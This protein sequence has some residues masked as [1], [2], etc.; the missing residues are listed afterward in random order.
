MEPT[1]ATNHKYK[2][3]VF[4]PTFNRARTLGH[5]YESLKA[6]TFHNFEWLIV[7]DGSTDN[8]RELL[9]QWRQKSDFPIRYVYQENSGKHV[10]FNLA[11]REAQGELFL[12]LDS[13]DTCV[14]EALA[15]FKFHWDSI[16]DYQR[17][18][19]S[20]VTALCADQHGKVVGDE[21][22]QDVTDSD[23]LEITYRFKVRGE[24]WGFL[25]TEVLRRYPFP[26]LEKQCPYVPEGVIWAA[27]ARRYKT[28]FVNE[29]LRIYWSD[30][31][32]AS[33][34]LTRWQL[35]RRAYG[36]LLWDLSVMNEQIDWFRYAPLQFMRSAAGYVRYS[37]HTGVGVFRQVKQ[38]NNLLA[39]ALWLMMWPVG[40]LIYLADRRE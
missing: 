11:A 1:Q 33:D 9:A 10:A 38:L 37:Y 21:F 19:F 18:E 13:D 27:I 22:P 7:D 16:P 35:S 8:T 24:K 36:H 12:V 40:L 32:P 14:P 31:S 39:K 3:T 20:G 28:R 25:R 17:E 34:Q 29:V 15:R 26:V 4:T 30:G 6:Q 2:F 23:S 5:V